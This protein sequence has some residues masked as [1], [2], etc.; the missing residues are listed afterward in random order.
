MRRLTVCATALAALAAC[1]EPASDNMVA[2]T[3]LRLGD[4]GFVRPQV[5]DAGPEHVTID[6]LDPESLYLAG[7]EAF[8]AGES[9]KAADLFRKALR[10][11]KTAK[12]WHA[13]GDALMTGGRFDEAADAFEDALV[14]EPTKRLSLMRRGRCLMNSGRAKEAVEAF[15]KAVELKGDDPL[16][17]RE[18]ADA[19]IEDKRDGE[20]LAQ[21]KR[22][23][24][25]DPSGAARDLKL[26]GEVLARGEKWAEA[27]EALTASAKAHPDPGILSE[28]GE[29]LVRTGDLEAAKGA[30]Q[31]AGRLDPKDPLAPETVAEIQLKQGDTAG[32]RTSF[33]AS[34]LIRDRPSP[35]LALGRLDLKEGKKDAAKAQLDKALAAAKGDDVAEVREIARYA[36]EV[37]SPA[38]AEKLLGVLAGEDAKEPA[39]FLEL[40]RARAAL[41][42]AKGVKQA[43]E[44]AKALLPKDDKTVCPPR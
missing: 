9:E 6:P 12:T 26:T 32:A 42:D 3:P 15:G 29:A 10:L 23:T 39:L 41:K 44:K 43:C 35:H 40:A 31:E 33:A 25:L 22:A 13:L 20:A 38:A 17:L 28:L 16:A 11:K 2:S 8:I 1:K 27:V 34:I 14:L 30:F 18:H 24:A 21:L 37:G 7:Q 4:G 19:L 5:G 36:M